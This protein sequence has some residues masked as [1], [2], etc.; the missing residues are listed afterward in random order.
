[1][2]WR[3]IVDKVDRAHEATIEHSNDPDSEM[4]LRETV[5]AELCASVNEVEN[6]GATRNLDEVAQGLGLSS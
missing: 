2:R 4:E 5:S 6:G 1:M 3:V